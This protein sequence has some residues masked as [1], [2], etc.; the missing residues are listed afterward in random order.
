MNEAFEK[1]IER[2]EKEKYTLLPLRKCQYNDLTTF[3]DDAI[4]IVQEVAEEYN[5]GWIHCKG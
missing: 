4:K 3:L 2:L 5:G 1:I